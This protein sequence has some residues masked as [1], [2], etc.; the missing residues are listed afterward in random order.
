MIDD[1]GDEK[2]ED[3]GQ[4]QNRGP[5]DAN[6]DLEAQAPSFLDGAGPSDGTH[7]SNQRP[8]FGAPVMDISFRMGLNDEGGRDGGE[9]VSNTAN[10]MTTIDGNVP[11]S[12]RKWLEA[13]QQ[14]EGSGTTTGAASSKIVQSAMSGGATSAA[15]R[16]QAARRQSMHSV[17]SIASL[18][19]LAMQSA[20]SVGSTRN[21][22]STAENSDADDDMSLSSDAKVDPHT[23][24]F[25]D[26]IES[27]GLN[28]FGIIA[29]DV[30]IHDE[31]DGSFHHAPGGYWR[32][33]RYQPGDVR[34][35]IALARVEDMTRKDFVP[36]TRQIPG[37][38]LAGY[39]WSLCT[40]HDHHC[41]WRDVR[42][43]TSDPDQ[44]P[45]LRMKLLEQARFGKATGIPF[46]IRGHRG[47]VLFLARDSASDAQLLELSNDC[48]L[49]VSADVIGAASARSI[50]QEA[51]KNLKKARTA[52]TLRR[53]RAKFIAIA[54]FSK[55][56]GKN[57]SAEDH[58]P[59][60]II[61]FQ[62][63]ETERLSSFQKLS[64]S[65]SAKMR[66]SYRQSLAA[67]IS[68]ALKHKARVTL[69]KC[70]GGGMTPPPPMPL[71]QV[72]WTFLGAFIT[73]LI[74]GGLNVV[75]S[76]ETG[77]GILL[78]PF[79]ALLT[80]Q[81]GLTPAP[82]SQPRNAICKHIE[83]RILTFTFMQSY[84][85]CSS[86]AIF[87]IEFLCITL[88]IPQMVKSLPF[89]LLFSSR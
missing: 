4:A 60:S 88:S 81:Y 22:L 70:K 53:L 32:Y 25:R 41:T 56:C 79:G 39:F 62:S 69:T 66:K 12:V 11:Q 61:D 89:H 37:A 21:V 51:C 28:A 15:T 83:C 18:K 31:D 49:R 20:T 1:I 64:A 71:R 80:L 14:R 9:D 17:N 8:T 50:T 2:Q 43:I 30:W 57:D 84:L 6:D 26:A 65:V 73:L 67:E 33:P 19:S 34:A 58:L 16:P 78:P 45:Y 40:H 85:F 24:A 36:P 52:A 63:E 75:L 76:K 44:P 27:A 74:L 29:V 72:I 5:V 77:Y 82:A 68:N 38:G 47:V 35:Q 23:K 42:A 3:K 13:Q 87:R 7:G 55:H 46:D 54:A 59:P 10:E 86:H 48:H